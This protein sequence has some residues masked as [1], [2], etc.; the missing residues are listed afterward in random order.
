MKSVT[1]FVQAEAPHIRQSELCASCHTLITQAFGPNGEVIGSLP[2]QMNYQE[3]QHSAFNKEERSCQSCHMPAAPGPVRASSVLGDARDT[4][5]PARVRRWE[6]VHGPD[7]EP[8]PHRA[9]R[10]GAALRARGHRPSHDPSAA[11]GHGYAR[12]LHAG[13][14]RERTA[15]QRR[16]PEPDR[17]QVPDRLP[18]PSHVAARHRARRAR[19]ARSSNLAPST[20]TGAIRGNDNDADPK[21]FEPHYEEITRPDQVQ[22]YEPILGDRTGVPT[23]GLLTATQYLKDNRLLPRGL[24][25]G[26]GGGG[27]WR[28]R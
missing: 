10:H 27:D 25:Q 14:D 21:R 5:G 28:L 15:L 1:G 4:D 19:H 3:W 7:A 9:R 22:I 6:R 24:R 8:V 23:T 16:R 12:R 17:P 2:E 26:D 13:T 11:A 18:V 20:R